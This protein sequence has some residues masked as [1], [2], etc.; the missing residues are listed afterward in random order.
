MGLTL[1]DL[2]YGTFL[3][4]GTLLA[5]CPTGKKNSSAWFGSWNEADDGSCLAVTLMSEGG[6]A[7]INEHRCGSK[8]PVICKSV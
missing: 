1:A 3:Q 5:Q 2:D 8:F 7:T 6:A 4:A